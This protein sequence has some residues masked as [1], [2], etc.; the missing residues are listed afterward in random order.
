MTDPLAGDCRRATALVVHY[1]ARNI[2]GCNE[3]LKEAVESDRVVRLIAALC[4]LFQVIV[5]ALITQLGM[6]C[7][8]EMVLDMANTTDG[9]PDIRR[10]ARLIAHHGNSNVDGVNS[11]LEDAA[12]ADRVTELVL[13]LL[14]LYETILPALYAPTGLRALQQTVLDFAAQEGA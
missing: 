14:N 1:S 6:A 9:D 2:D 5:P 8:S 13:A 4:D 11:V 7:M 10:A 12:E 3:V